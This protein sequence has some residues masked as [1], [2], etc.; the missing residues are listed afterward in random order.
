MTADPNRISVIE[1]Q[2]NARERELLTRA[3]LDAPKP[4]KVTLEVGTWL[5]GGSTL[6]ILRALEKNGCGHLWGGASRPIGAPTSG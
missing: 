1:G 6:H 5:G 2:L 3:I 4:P